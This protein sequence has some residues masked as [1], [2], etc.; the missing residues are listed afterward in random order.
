MASALRHAI[1]SAILDTKATA[2]F[3]FLPAS[4]ELMTTSPYSKLLNAY[5][6]VHIFVASLGLFRKLPLD[7]KQIAKV[8]HKPAANMIVPIPQKAK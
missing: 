8:P 2:T 6:C 7:K 1:Y 3:M 5:P 4:R